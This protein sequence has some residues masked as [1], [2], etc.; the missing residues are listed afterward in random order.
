MTDEAPP[1]ITDIIAAQRL[2]QRARQALDERGLD[3]SAAWDVA[4]TF[5]AIGF[6]IGLEIIERAAPALVE[7]A[8][9]AATSWIEERVRR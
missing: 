6:T 5:G 8:A 9:G 2:A 1:P 4:R 3:F 7:A